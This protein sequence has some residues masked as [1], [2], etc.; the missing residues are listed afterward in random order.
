MRIM[1][2]RNIIV[3]TGSCGFIGRNAVEF[4]LRHGATVIGLDNCV[5]P[6]TL[7]NLQNL[8]SQEN[9]LH[10]S[11][12]VRDGVSVGELLNNVISN[13]GEITGIIHLAGQVSYVQSLKNP[14]Y[15][16]QVNL[17]S[18]VQI[19]EWVREY[20]PR[21]KI[22][23]SSSNKVYGDLSEIR[24]TEEETRYEL[25]D[26]P[27]GLPSDL[28]LDFKGGYGCS[29]AA[30]DRYIVDFS[31]QYGLD[32]FSLRQSAIAG[33][34]QHPQADQGWVGFLIQETRAG[35]RIKLSGFGK[36]VRDVLHVDD[37]IQL[38]DTILRASTSGIASEKRAFN[39]GG[40]PSN[41]LSLLELFGLLEHSYGLHADFESGPFRPSD[42]MVFV[43]SNE[44]VK[45]LFNWKPQRGLGNVID[46]FFLDRSMEAHRPKTSER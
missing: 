10:H 16:L 15:D 1:R 21:T 12:D 24:F 9:Y 38:F 20:S 35:R 44:E 25:P 3:I 43:S 46:S 31:R 5:R 28:A 13:V 19:L 7:T 11:V 4:F 2:E 23:F 29:K 34:H 42:Q 30:A 39:V 18:T 32:T 45:D 6:G 37:L 14:T 27:L 8:L 17:L 36:Q 22:I 40:G 41:T 33:P 26:Y